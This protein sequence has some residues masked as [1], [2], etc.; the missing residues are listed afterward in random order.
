MKKHEWWPLM[1]DINSTPAETYYW[2]KCVNCK[3][4][5]KHLKHSVDC[6]DIEGCEAVD[7]GSIYPL[8]SC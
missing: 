8:S 6:P 1:S 2:W 4:E 5:T 3:K 7:K